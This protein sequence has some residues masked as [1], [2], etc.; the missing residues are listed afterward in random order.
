[1]DIISNLSNELI[2]KILHNLPYTQIFNCRKLCKNWC[3][4]IDN[5]IRLEDLVVYFKSFTCQKEWSFTTKPISANHSLRI[6]NFKIFASELAKKVFGNLKKLKIQNCLA[7]NATIDSAQLNFFQK[8]E[9]LEITIIDRK[10]NKLRFP[11]L[12]IL[13]INRCNRNLN[14]KLPKLTT[15]RSSNNL[16]FFKFDFPTSLTFLEIYTFTSEEIKQFVN[17]EYI[18]CKI[19]QPNENEFI[20]KLVKLKQL[21]FYADQTSLDKLNE[22]KTQLK[23]EN[24]S[25]HF[26]NIFYDQN[27]FLDA[28]KLNESS[29]DHFKANYQN[30]PD[31]LPFIEEID[32][33]SVTASFVTIPSNFFS[34][35]GSVETLIVKQKIKDEQEFLNFA[36]GLK[37]IARLKFQG[38]N[39]D[40]FD[41]LPIC[42]PYLIDLHISQNLFQ[43]NF[44]FVSKLKNLL[45][46][47]NETINQFLSVN[48]V[49]EVLKN[50]HYL[51]KFVFKYQQIPII[52]TCAPFKTKNRFILKI[53]AKNGTYNNLDDLLNALR[54][55]KKTKFIN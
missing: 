2:I 18:Y 29:V 26:I 34:K 49:G 22:Q 31:H 20:D 7:L 1:M 51:N 5:N 16:S 41:Q 8:L 52:I 13:V 3:T 50:C 19:I 44:N 28:L 43:I 11:N 17:L 45:F 42:C 48:L 9:H 23:R 35:F 32:Y 12:K 10:I 33:Q 38:V 25:I 24:L 40:K 15:F 39:L 46:F 37:N 21:V 53:G 14:L 4:V 47:E 30:L 36:K 55:D 27:N 6:V 54:N